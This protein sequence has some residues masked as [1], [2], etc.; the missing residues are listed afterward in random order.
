MHATLY[1][2]KSTNVAIRNL[3]MQVGQIAKKL[4]EIPIKSFG[5]NTEVN[6]KEECKAIKALPPKVKDLGSF[7]IP[8]TI[9]SHK[10]REALI[11]LGSSINLMALSVLE[12]IGGLKV[13]PARMTLFMADGSTKRPYGVVEDVMVQTDNLKFLVDFVVMEM[14]EDFE[15]PIILG[16]PFMKTTKVII[17]VDDGTITLKDKEQE[18]TFNVFNAEQQI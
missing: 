6:P 1:N 11:D 2:Q 15:I 12:K 17:N 14:E 8:Y 3:E 13:K 16:R 9:T 7:T 10:I 4:E 5:A 18:V